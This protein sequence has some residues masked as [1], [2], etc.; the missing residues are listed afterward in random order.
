MEGSL[1]SPFLT[2]VAGVGEPE[3]SDSGVASSVTL[4][5]FSLHMVS[6]CLRFLTARKS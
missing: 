3:G 4:V 2:G 5:P 1:D 6:V